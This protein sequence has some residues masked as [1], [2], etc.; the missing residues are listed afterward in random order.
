MSIPKGA[1]Q[2]FFTACMKNSILRKSSSISIPEIAKTNL[3]V[4]KKFLTPA[5]SKIGHSR[6]SK[7]ISGLL[8]N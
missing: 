5:K 4:F 3:V 7:L 2:C 8:K 1:D 6:H